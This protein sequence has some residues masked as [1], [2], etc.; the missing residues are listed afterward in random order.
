MATTTN[1]NLTTW[2]PNDYFNDLDLKTNWEKV[3]AHDH[4]PANDGGVRIKSN[5]IANEAITNAKL[6][7]ESVTDEKIANDTITKFKLANDLVV[8]LDKAAGALSIDTVFGTDTDSDVRGSSASLKL[9]DGAIVDTHI[10]QT[11]QINPG[12][13]AVRTQSGSPLSATNGVIDTSAVAGGA[14]TGPFGSL[15]ISPNSIGPSELAS[16]AVGTDKIDTGAVTSAKIANGT[17]VS[18]DLDSSVRNGLTNTSI[19]WT[20][21]LPQ[22]AVFGGS[23]DYDDT[24]KTGAFQRINNT[25]H[26]RVEFSGTWLVSTSAILI[27]LPS[28]ALAVANG[29]WRMEWNG[30]QDFGIAYVSG[31]SYQMALLGLPKNYLN[32]GT[33]SLVGGTAVG[34]GGA[35]YSIFSGT[36]SISITYET[37]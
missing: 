10:S 3:D 21:Y 15:A 28:T 12:K 4:D 22:L 8:A 13:I 9:R 29:H 27:S 37:A 6:A 2:G 19:P 14:V 7:P 5:G 36:L 24:S 26:A 17:I 34:N 30:G 33:P 20:G 16:S 31:G 11:A 25:V 32:S 18:E 35:F 1:M 23:I